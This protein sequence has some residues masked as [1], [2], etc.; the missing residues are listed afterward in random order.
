M[1]C[2][3]ISNM[4]TIYHHNINTCN[5]KNIQ[6]SES[7]SCLPILKQNFTILTWPT[8]RPVQEFFASWFSTCTKSLLQAPRGFRFGSGGGPLMR[9]G[10]NDGW[11]HTQRPRKT[12]G[13]NQ[14]SEKFSTNHL[15]II[16]VHITN[17]INWDFK[18][19]IPAKCCCQRSLPFARSSSTSSESWS[20]KSSNGV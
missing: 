1:Q 15:V 14:N 20:N 12:N 5:H 3:I 17:L 8:H 2:L 6:E 4:I 7:T 13:W 18:P 10:E 19:T 9:G 11:C 16:F